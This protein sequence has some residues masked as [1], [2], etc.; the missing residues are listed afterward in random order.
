MH[1]GRRLIDVL[2]PEQF[3]LNIEF[4]IPSLQGRAS[5]PGSQVGRQG[6]PSYRGY[7]KGIIEL[8]TQCS[9]VRIRMP[10]LQVIGLVEPYR[11][12]NNLVIMTMMKCPFH[13]WR[14]LEYPEGTTDLQQVYKSF[15]HTDQHKGALHSE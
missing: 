5:T 3:L 10:L 11:L 12:N 13:W 6:M 2:P 14:K 1:Q 7:P 4:R 9:T 15:T 8:V